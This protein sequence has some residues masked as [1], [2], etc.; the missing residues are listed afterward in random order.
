MEQALGPVEFNDVNSGVRAQVLAQDIEKQEKSLES[1]VSE[2]ERSVGAG[3]LVEVPRPEV[4]AQETEMQGFGSPYAPVGQER[5]SSENALGV[6]CNP[7]PC[8][9]V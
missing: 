1:Q 6:F 2:V 9:S 5:E 4:L 3:E 8:F 7:K